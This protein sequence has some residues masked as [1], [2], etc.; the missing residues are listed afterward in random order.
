[1]NY[2]ILNFNESLGV[3]TVEVEGYPI[4]A[5][6]LPRDPDGMV[7]TGKDLEDFISERLPVHV[8][9]EP[10]EEVQINNAHEIHSLVEPTVEVVH[11]AVEPITE[12][13][14]KKSVPLKIENLKWDVSISSTKMRIGCHNHTHKQWQ[15]FNDKEIDEM[16]EGALDFWNTWKEP[17]LA[18]CSIRKAINKDK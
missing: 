16:E 7:P 14:F 6:T 12:E 2:K 13:E 18:M 5:L 10:L 3:I 9:P 1:M 4:F 8:E 15:D 11:E 17:L